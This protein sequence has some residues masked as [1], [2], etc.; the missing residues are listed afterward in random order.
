MTGDTISIDERVVN[1][2]SPKGRDIAILTAQV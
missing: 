1:D 2:V